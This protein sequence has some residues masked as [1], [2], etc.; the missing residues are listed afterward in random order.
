[1][2]QIPPDG[3]TS[4]E[5]ADPRYAGLEEQPAEQILLAILTA[6]ENALAAIRPAIPVMAAAAEEAARR[7]ASDPKARIIYVGAGT[8]GRLGVQDGVEL[9]P[10]YG[11]LRT[12]F[13][14]AG[15]EQALTRSVEGAEDDINAAT[16]QV[17]ELNIT[18]ADICIAVSAS[19]KT[20]FTVAACRAA[21]AA[22]AQTIGIASNDNSPLLQAAEH[23]IL[24]ASGPEPVAGSTRM[25]AGTAQKAA[26]NMIST[27]VMMR[28]GHVYD[29]LMVD[30]QLTNE[31]LR[32]RAE[33]MIARI[34]QCDDAAAADALAKT[35]G[36]VK[37]AV[38]VAKGL[39]PEQGE[40]RL[41]QTGGNLKRA[42]Q[43]PAI[44]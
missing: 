10:T 24:I 12:E 19:G 11:W 28:L 2:E 32:R 27:L 18:P 22:G 42:L 35:G 6:Q 20:P 34:A 41:A 9:A 8:P 43:A 23:K 7:L 13:V 14:I 3:E 33:K 26:L 21:R 30:V 39:T 16:Q 4:T 38:L 17:A 36:R 25:S 31:K 15:R 1:M 5:A 29:G 37:I 40:E 44:N